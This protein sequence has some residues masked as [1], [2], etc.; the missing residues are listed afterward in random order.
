MNPALVISLGLYLIGKSIHTPPDHPVF[1]L[2]GNIPQNP[3]CSHNPAEEVYEEGIPLCADIYQQKNDDF[4]R[5][6]GKETRGHAPLNC[7]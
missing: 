4:R 1:V 6:H 3:S 7:A 2:C 5:H